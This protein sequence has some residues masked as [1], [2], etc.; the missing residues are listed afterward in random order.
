MVPRTFALWGKERLMEA[1]RMSTWPA[2]QWLEAFLLAVTGIPWIVA[3]TTLDLAEMP[4]H[5][6]RKLLTLHEQTTDD[7]LL[8]LPMWVVELTREDVPGATML[9]FI[10]S[11]THETH[12]SER[13]HF[14]LIAR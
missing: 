3:A 9:R 7:P 4:Q 1:P 2:R 5:D 12:A 14:T 8:P 13:D 6:S 11:V 10:D